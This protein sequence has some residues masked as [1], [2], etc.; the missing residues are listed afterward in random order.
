MSRPKSMSDFTAL[1]D[2]SM[3]PPMHPYDKGKEHPR[4]KPS[5]SLA[6]GLIMAS[7]E[8]QSPR[9]FVNTSSSSTTTMTTTSQDSNRKETNTVDWSDGL[10][11]AYAQTDA[12]PTTPPSVLTFSSASTASEWW[13]LVSTFYPS[14]SR[15]GPQFFLLKS[16]DS[17][18]DIFSQIHSNP[19]LH[20]LQ[21][22]WFYASPSSTSDPTT[23]P[24][25]I[26]LQDPR[27]Y[28]LASTLSS[29]LHQTPASPSPEIS[30][31]LSALTTALSN[32]TTLLSTNTSQIHALS[33][34]QSTGLATMQEINE[35]T[36]AQIKELT[37][38]QTQ[39]QATVAANATHYL[40]LANESFSAR[41]EIR[42]VLGENTTQLKQLST[43]HT[44]L[45]KTCTNLASSVSKLSSSVANM[46]DSISTLSTPPPPTPVQ[47]SSSSTSPFPALATAGTGTSTRSNSFVSDTSTLTMAPFSSMGNRISPPPRKLN[48][49]IKGVWYEYDMGTSVGS[50]GGSVVGS[51]STA[52]SPS[53]R[54]GVAFKGVVEGGSVNG[55]PSKGVSFKNVVDVG[56]SSPV[57]S[58]PVKNTQVK[59]LSTKGRVVGKS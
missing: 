52:G 58:T 8:T 11:Y 15:L 16:P 4:K 12:T 54:K 50:G 32:L 49:R 46:K 47:H 56:T 53:Q 51:G 27:G 36:T 31:E 18:P 59:S 28:P 43:A 35:S 13:F 30:T 14:S 3:P 6:A 41:D 17:Y 10:F 48:R 34:A 9:S 21:Q 23:A 19:H 42:T 24:P 22:K 33:V 7:A 20:H 57:K 39:L 55:S 1:L 2:A 25:I 26:P 37:S 44:S 45:T 38:T 29:C 5:I 40:A